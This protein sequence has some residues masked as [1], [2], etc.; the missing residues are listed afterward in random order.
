MSSTRLKR[1]GAAAAV[2]LIVFV[3]SSSP[4]LAQS[5]GDLSKLLGG[6]SGHSHNS[7]QSAAAVTVQRGA[8]PYTGTFIGKQT[9]T[10]GSGTDALDTQFACYPASDPA[11]AETKTFVCYAAQ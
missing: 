9:T 7:N 8:A 10:T 4:S 5:F 6:G 11:F 2:G 1:F 3:G